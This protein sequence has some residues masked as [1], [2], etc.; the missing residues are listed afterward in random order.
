VSVF[1]LTEEQHNAYKA[2]RARECAAVDLPDNGLLASTGKAPGCNPVSV[3]ARPGSN[4]GESTIYPLVN[5]CRMAGLP[6]PTPEH[7]FHPTRKW[8]ADYAFLF[9]S[10]RVL[11]EIDG[12]AWTQG[13]H[14]RGTGFIADME[15]LNAAALLG[16]MV[17]RY[18]PNQLDRAVA[19]LRIMFAGS[20]R[21]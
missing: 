1:R 9:T 4:P 12:G 8:R 17:L 19:D 7:R 20:Q 5:L 3:A 6:E 13:R 10:P 14:T 2:K 18:A 15:K 16:F 21:A 11:V